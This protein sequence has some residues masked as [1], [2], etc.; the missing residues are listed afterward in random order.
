MRRLALFLL[1]SSF[2]YS[3]V[4]NVSAAPAPV[5][6]VANDEINSYQ[7]KYF[8]VV[9]FAGKP[10]SGF[11]NTI[12]YSEGGYAGI[13]TFTGDFWIEK[14]FMYYGYYDGYLT[15]GQFQQSIIND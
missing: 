4:S 8:K 14:D 3:G 7:T 6:T 2:L 5:E 10:Y 12:F 13:L 11:P 1:L 15:Y 9:H